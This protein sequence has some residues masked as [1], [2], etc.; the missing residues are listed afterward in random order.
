MSHVYILQCRDGSLYTGAAKD[1]DRRVGEHQAGSASKYT[2][3]RRPVTL[4]WARRVRS[5]P[6][7][8]QLE[9]RIKQLDRSQKMAL[10]AGTFVLARAARRARQPAT[11]RRRSATAPARSGA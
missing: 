4:V 6:R 8:L 3:A 1:L 11:G 2:R 5:W 7:A 9:Y 10:V